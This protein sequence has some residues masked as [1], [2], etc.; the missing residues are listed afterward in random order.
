MVMDQD[1]EAPARLLGFPGSVVRGGGGKAVIELS[2]GSLAGCIVVGEG[3]TDCW[4]EMAV[5]LHV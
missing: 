2:L 3:L 5:F 1:T 4:T